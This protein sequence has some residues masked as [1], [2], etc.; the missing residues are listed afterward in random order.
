MKRR[1]RFIRIR[2]TLQSM[3][4]LYSEITEYNN[5][6]WSKCLL[7]FWLTFGIV[8]VL[9]LSLTF[10]TAIPITLQIIFIYLIIFAT[11]SFLFIIF[12]ASSVTSSANKSYKILNS[13]FL[14]YFQQNKNFGSK[15]ISNK[16]K[17]KLIL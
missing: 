11:T 7:V 5:T 17:V 15:Q 8:I 3:D 10:F 9:L 4:S 6:F 1:K 2:E 13:L 14:S 16:L 12:T